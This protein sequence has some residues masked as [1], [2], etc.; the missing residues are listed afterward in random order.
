MPIYLATKSIFLAQ[1][2][3]F[4]EEERATNTQTTKLVQQQE[5]HDVA[6]SVAFQSRGSKF[7]LHKYFF[8]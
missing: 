6:R 7:D 1:N 3:T 8:K 4:K 5:K 2:S